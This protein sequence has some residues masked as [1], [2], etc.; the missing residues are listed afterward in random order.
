[1]IDLILSNHRSS[2]M[3]TAVLETGISD[4]H[5]LIFSNLKRSFANGPPEIIYYRDL[6]NFGQKVFNS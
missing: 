1:M 5:K 2:F 4:H 3:K 6:K